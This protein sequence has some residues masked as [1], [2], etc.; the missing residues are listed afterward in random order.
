MQAFAVVH[1]LEKHRQ[2]GAGFGDGSVRA[3]INL[4]GFE[5]LHKALHAPVF[6]WAARAAHADANPEV[7]EQRQVGTATILD[8]A[9]RVMY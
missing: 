9:I 4:L 5:R 3:A 7:L 8:A 2:S 6:P 1:A